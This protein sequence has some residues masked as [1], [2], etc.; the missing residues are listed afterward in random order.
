VL[1]E[2]LV[3]SESGSSVI[4]FRSDVAGE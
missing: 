2:G 4:T 3:L 1:S